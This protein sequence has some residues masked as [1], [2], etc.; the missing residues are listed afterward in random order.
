MILVDIH[1]K[2]LMNYESNPSVGEPN[3]SCLYNEKRA[4]DLSLQQIK[5]VK[6]VHL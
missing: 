2:H 4:T 3:Q 1:K 6:G 5:L